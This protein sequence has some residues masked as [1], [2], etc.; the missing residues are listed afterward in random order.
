MILSGRS[1]K[2]KVN[3]GEISIDPVPKPIQYQPAS[4][5]I[6]LGEEIVSVDSGHSLKGEEK[7]L[8]PNR[9]YLATTKET[10]ELPTDIA[11]QLAGRSTVGR[12]GII[13]HKTAGFLDPGFTGTVTLELMN[14]GSSPKKLTPGDRVG[15]LVFFVLD[16][17]SCGYDGKYQN[18]EGPTPARKD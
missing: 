13:I 2:K 4:L 18:Q 10:I 5:D 1:I 15:Q 9:R 6:R 17:P 7:Y 16:Q 3:L 8:A 12:R 14:L 11:A